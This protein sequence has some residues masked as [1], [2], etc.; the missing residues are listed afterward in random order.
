MAD[1]KCKSCGVISLLGSMDNQSSYYEGEDYR[2]EVDDGP[3]INDYRRMHD[4]EQLR[5][6]GITGSS[7]YRDKVVADIGCGGGSFLDNVRG[8]AKKVIAIEPNVLFR[9]H[10]AD[11]GYTCFSYVDQALGAHRNSVDIVVSFSV[12]EHLSDPLLNLKEIRELL[13]PEGKLFLSTPNAD[14]FMLKAL[15][16]L[17][18]SF[19]YRKAHLWYFTS[20]SLL[21]LFEL[22]GFKHIKIMP[23]QRFGLSNFIMWLKDGKPKGECTSEYISPVVDAVWKTDLEQRLICDYLYV[24]AACE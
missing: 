12:I 2:K 13:V 10:L 5:N 1:F 22:A 11:N 8:L 7:I 3:S 4:S 18:P 9:E 6:L 20:F 14:D 19:Y 17:Y 15:P 24:E 21:K 16:E 23:Y